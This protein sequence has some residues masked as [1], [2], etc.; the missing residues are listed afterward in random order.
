[1]CCT[2]LSFLYQP[3]D[4]PI[5]EK[6]KLT[7]KNKVP[8]NLKWKKSFKNLKDIRGPATAAN[9]LTEG[10]YGIMV[11]YCALFLFVLC[12]SQ[13][14]IQSS[15]LYCSFECFGYLSLAKYFYVQKNCYTSLHSYSNLTI[16]HIAFCDSANSDMFILSLSIES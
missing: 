10:Q 5:P 11:N 3:T 13:G 4:I 8:Q 15:N 1:M 2:L 6:T 12:V 16:L 9:I 14:I 7:F